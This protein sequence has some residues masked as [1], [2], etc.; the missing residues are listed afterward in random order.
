MLGLSQRVTTLTNRC[1]LLAVSKTKSV[2]DLQA[3][4]EAGQRHFGENYVDEIAEKAG[5]LPNDISWHFIGHLQS[6]KIK[7]L[8]TSVPN[9]AMIETVDTVKLAGKLNKEMSKLG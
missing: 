6:N 1:L 4:Y 3:A 7:K 5:Q 9:L 2:E 8:L